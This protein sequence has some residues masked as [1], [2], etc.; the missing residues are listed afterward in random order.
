MSNRIF[1]PF[2]LSKAKY[3]GERQKY[4]STGSLLQWPQQP[5]LDLPETITGS[6]SGSKAVMDVK[7]PSSGT[8]NCAAC[9]PLGHLL[10]AGQG[11]QTFITSGMGIALKRVG[12]LIKQTRQNS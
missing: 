2:C 7:I 12:I 10:K 11:S 9:L 8:A 3:E 5:G 6:W 1:F 4:L